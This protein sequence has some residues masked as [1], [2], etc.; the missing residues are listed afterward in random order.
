MN[1]C[2]I[3]S[4]FDFIMYLINLCLQ[5]LADIWARKM[6]SFLA[7]FGI[8][9]GTFTVIMLLALGTGFASASKNNMMRVVDGAL[10]VMPGQTSKS[11]LG[12]SKGQTINIKA[13]AIMNLKKIIPSILKASP[14]MRS[15]ASINSEK[16]RIHVTGVSEDYS[17]LRKMDLVRGSRPINILDIKNRKHVAIIGDKLKNRIFGDTNDVMGNSIKINNIPFTV[18]G[19]A[20]KSGKTVYNWHRNGTIIPY[21]TYI[22]MFGDQNTLFFIIFPDP[23]ANPRLVEQSMRNYLAH[24]YHYAAHDKAAINILDTTKIY[25][26]MRWFFIGLQIFLGI[27]GALALGVGSLGVANIMFLIVVERTREIGLRLA[28]G[29]SDQHILL[30]VILEASIIVALGGIIG[31][32]LSYLTILVLQSIQLPEWLGVPALSG[33]VVITSITILAVLGLLAGY[34]P[35][36]RASKMDPV[37]ALGH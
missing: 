18:I 33:V 9:W 15:D 28:I 4:L 12:F 11:F 14:I 7:L 3:F 22:E 2:R 16:N 27:C 6:R 8:V 37:E 36:K 30:Q 13:S 10:F 5:I 20:E 26:F 34:F 1:R 25:Q 21:S 35:A 29:A 19:A 24:K 23:K 32:V 31:F 17:Y